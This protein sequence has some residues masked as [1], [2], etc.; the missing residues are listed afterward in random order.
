MARLI[1]AGLLLAATA[2]V[3]AQSAPMAPVGGA[4]AMGRAD[5]QL[6]VEKQFAKRD[7]NRDGV[8]TTEEMGHR[9][10]AM[11]MRRMSERQAARDPNAAF[12]R[13]D[14][15]RDG[16]INRDEFARARQV[17]IEQRV[18]VNQA[19]EPGMKQRRGRH[20][21]GMMGAAMLRMADANRDGRVTLAEA[22]TGALRHFDMI[23]TNRDGR[24]TPE[25][26]AAGRAH[27]RQMRH[28]G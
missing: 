16:S 14:A 5:L 27:I 22:T 2:P 20:G 11:K 23:D 28:A 21:G 13:I 19:G 3:L 9:G 7:S 4:R 1:V 12:D 15:N 17:R 24:I 6:R 26:R 10:G 8:L 25:E 18:A